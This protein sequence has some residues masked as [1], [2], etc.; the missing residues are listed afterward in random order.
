VS[1]ETIA[2]RIAGVRFHAVGRLYHFGAAGFPE[3]QIG[4]HVIVETSRGYQLGQVVCFVSPEEASSRRL[5]SIQRVATPRDLVMRQAWQAKEEDALRK[6]REKA[7]EIGGFES[8]R[9]VKAAY[10]HD[11]SLLTLLYTAEQK[12]S[13]DRLRRALRNSFRMRIETRQ[14]GPRDAAKLLGG[15]GACGQP[16]C[17]SSFLAEFNPI[18]IKMAKA[19]NVSLNPSEITGMCGRLR[20]CLIYEH[21]QYTEAR[22]QLPRK[23]KHVRTPYG[24]GKVIEVHPLRSTVTVLVGQQRFE[25]KSEEIEPLDEQ[26]RQEGGKGGCGRRKGGPCGRECR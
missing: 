10:N 4:D 2:D 3:L 23:K 19:Q 9:F 14:I 6:C 24:E 13:T 5:K 18:S 16:R 1:Q 11:G 15:Y 25:V 8:V 22:E 21:E 17:C 12:T 7:A 20:C 26:D